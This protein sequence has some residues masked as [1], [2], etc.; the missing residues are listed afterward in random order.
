MT[1]PTWIKMTI[2]TNNLQNALLGTGVRSDKASTHRQRE[3]AGRDG[4]CGACAPPNIAALYD[5]PD[6]IHDG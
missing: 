5:S 3:F 2:T 6:G 1:L 4:V